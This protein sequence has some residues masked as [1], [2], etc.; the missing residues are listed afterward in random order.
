MFDDAI[1]RTSRRNFQAVGR[2]WARIVEW[3]TQ[4]LAHPTG[5]GPSNRM[6]VNKDE[7]QNWGFTTAA[8]TSACDVAQ[9]MTDHLLL[10]PHEP[11]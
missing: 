11:A 5:H 2:T 1:A 6:I 10:R 7:K 4:P 3:M 9:H 8:L